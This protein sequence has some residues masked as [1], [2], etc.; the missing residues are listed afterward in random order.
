MHSRRIAHCDV[1]SENVLLDARFNLKIVDFGCARYSLDEHANP[2]PYDDADGIGSLK[3]NA[4]E[5]VAHLTKGVYQADSIDVFAAG[6]FLFEL[7]MKC[8][9]FKSADIKDEHYSKLAGLEK[10]KFWDIFNSKL[11]PSPDFKGTPRPTQTSSNACW[12]PTPRNASRCT[13]FGSTPGRTES[14]RAGRTTRRR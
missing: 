5:L 14:V 4:P 1:K 10:K 7:V 11:T 3:C 13:A 8:E 12:P 9:P 6:C 2:I